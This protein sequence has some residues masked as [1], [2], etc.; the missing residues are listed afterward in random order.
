MKKSFFGLVFMTLFFLL[1]LCSKGQILLTDRNTIKDDTSRV[2]RGAFV[3]SFDL[4]NRSTSRDAESI[5]NVLENDLIP[6]Y[7][8]RNEENV[9]RAIELMDEY[10]LDRDD[11]LEKMDEF[12]MDPKTQRRAAAPLET[13]TTTS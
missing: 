7:F 5:Y 8:D 4:K 9:P 10:G 2:F 11:V 12:N 1:P 6:K 3:F 13:P